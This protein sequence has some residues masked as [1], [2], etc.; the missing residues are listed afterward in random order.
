[1]KSKV[2]NIPIE[3]MTYVFVE[4]IRKPFRL[5]LYLKAVSSGMLHKDSEE[6]QQAMDILDI[7]DVRSFRKYISALLNENWIGYDEKT[8]IYFIR[9]F[10]F[11]RE[12][13]AFIKRSTALFHIDSDIIDLDAFMFAAIV[14]D[15]INR[16]KSYREIQKKEDGRTATKRR[17]VAK[18]VLSPSSIPDY[19]GMS[20]AGMGRPLK[21]SQTRSHEL[22]VR[23]ETNGYL[24]CNNMF[25]EVVV[26]DKPDRSIKSFIGRGDP[27][28]AKKIRIYTKKRGKKKVIIAAEQ[29][30]DEVIPLIDYKSYRLRK[31]IAKNFLPAIDGSQR[32]PVW[33]LCVNEKIK[34]G[35]IPP[36]YDP[37]IL[38]NYVF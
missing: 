36:E 33:A 13:H 35:I 28:L 37:Q 9:G 4:D 16:L 34:N 17:G 22:K 5:F 6:F 15:R 11:I 25:R 8:G 23:A 7:K 21:L 32:P 19:L 3:V 38:K 26:M 12:Q 10:Q 31:K 18:Q 2:L 20:V 30:H 29:L 14:G 24:K 1:M 27:E